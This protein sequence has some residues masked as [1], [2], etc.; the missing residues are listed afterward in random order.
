M[1]DDELLS[2]MLAILEDHGRRLAAIEQAIR[3]LD[4][5]VRGAVGRD[6]AEGKRP[7]PS[8]PAEEAERLRRQWAET[9]R[10]AEATLADLDAFIPRSQR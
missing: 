3:N 10:R 6:K 8:S 9:E 7:G 2:R 5:T 4:E 1:S